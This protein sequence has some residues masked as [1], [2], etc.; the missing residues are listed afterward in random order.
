[1]PLSPDLPRQPT[2]RQ[3]PWKVF[4]LMGAALALMVAVFIATQQPRSVRGQDTSKA[5]APREKAPEL[6]GGVA[7]L[8]WGHIGDGITAAEGNRPDAGFLIMRFDKSNPNWANSG[9]RATVPGTEAK[10]MGSYFPKGS[11]TTKAAFEKRGCKA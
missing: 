8:N 11:Y 5:K 7:W 10:I 1:M 3:W 9:D 4:I 6:D 2:L